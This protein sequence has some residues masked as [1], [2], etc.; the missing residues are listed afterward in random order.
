MTLKELPKLPDVYLTPMI[1]Q[2]CTGIDKL[3][4]KLKESMNDIEKQCMIDSATKDGIERYEKIMRIVSSAN[5]S[6]ESR[7][8]AC[9]YKWNSFVPYTRRDLDEKLANWINNDFSYNITTQGIVKYLNLY[10]DFKEPNQADY[11]YR[12]LVQILPCDFVINIQDISN[13]EH[14]T[15][16]KMNTSISQSI[17][18]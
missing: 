10:V 7:K 17:E 2:L 6:L 18:G 16:Y 8:Q 9:M 14:D 4:V 5:D 13:I 1:K 15:D 11:I 12:Q 3:F